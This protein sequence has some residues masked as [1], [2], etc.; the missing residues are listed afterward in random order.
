M[1]Q[2]WTSRH[3]RLVYRMTS[4]CTSSSHSWYVSQAEEEI[5]LPTILCRTSYHFKVMYTI[6]E[7]WSR[8]DQE[9]F[10]CCRWRWGLHSSHGTRQR[11]VSVARQEYMQSNNMASPCCRL[12]KLHWVPSPDWGGHSPTLG[13]S[14]FSLGRTHKFALIEHDSG[15]AFW[16][17]ACSSCGFSWIIPETASARPLWRCLPSYP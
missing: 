3:V 14:L 16:F 2:T 12:D 15:L 17:I 11:T 7:S 13:V 6:D 8:W 10:L 5:V 4:Y 1:S 9:G